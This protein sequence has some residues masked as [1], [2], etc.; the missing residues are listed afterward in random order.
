M[1][2][3]K[4]EGKLDG[5]VVCQSHRMALDEQAAY[6]EQIKGLSQAESAAL[7]DQISAGN[8]RASDEM[9]NLENFAAAARSNRG[10]GLKAYS[11]EQ[12]RKMMQQVRQQAMSPEELSTKP[13]ENLAQ[14]QDTATKMIG[15]DEAA[16]RFKE[17]GEAPDMEALE[18]ETEKGL[19][20][21]KGATE[22][23]KAERAKSEQKHRRDHRD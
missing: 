11:K 9:M 21:V 22:L 14:I 4:R 1:E 3:I 12:A 10:E 20:R 2:Y 5:D 17:S 15:K 6:L 16:A 8:A 23:L 19:E 18:K 13:F 7:A